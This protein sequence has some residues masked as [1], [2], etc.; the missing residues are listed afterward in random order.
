MTADEFLP[1]VPA[2]PGWVNSSRD[3]I[4]SSSVGEAYVK[5]MWVS[6]DYDDYS[7]NGPVSDKKALTLAAFY[8]GV[9]LISQ[10]MATMPIH[11][12]KPTKSGA[13]E[14]Q[15]QHV[16]EWAFNRTSNGWKTP[17]VSKSQIQSH[18]LFAGNSVSTIS[19][20][21][22]GQGIQYETYLPINTLFR[23]NR[24]N[25][26][27]Y[28]LR[29]DPTAGSTDLMLAIDGRRDYSYAEYEADEVLHF[30]A[31]SLDGYSGLS[32][33]KQAR[34]SL[35]L[36]L[37]IEKFGHKFFT[38]GRPAGF[39][40]KEGKLSKQ[41]KEIAKEEWHHFQEGVHNA[42]NVGLL[43]GGWD[44]KSMGYT[45]DDAQFLAT[46]EFQVL[47]IARWLR[48][49]PHMLGEISK[50][51]NSNI[52]SL[53]LEF[54]MYTLLPWIKGWEEE[55]NLK[56][57]TKKEQSM[58]FQA[59]YDVDAWLRGDSKTRSTVEEMDI[60]N[61]TRTIQ[62]VRNSRFYP[63]YADGMGTEPLII[64]SQLDT[65]KNVINGTSKLHG[66]DKPTTKTSKAMATGS[67]SFG[68][69]LV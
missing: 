60:R 40:T 34:S 69:G 35:D 20:N 15:D 46:R 55:I 9:S 23:V 58:G 19:R 37:T 32:V 66:V 2:A 11:V 44:W 5:E 57:F 28:L 63:A 53:M 42:F 22:R 67:D 27:Q 48:I 1:E 7:N 41:A 52:E 33:L 26:P 31:F 3:S 8:S 6:D 16:V 36:S 61:G 18:L 56:M 51:T 65:L 10:A 50:A 21:G 14:R 68:E 47:E 64:A 45:N 43:S 4:G 59:I 30:K 12:F 13:W 62:E 24:D 54:I 25:S 29:D 39:L 17:S 49:P 38:K